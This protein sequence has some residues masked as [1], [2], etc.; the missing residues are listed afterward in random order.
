MSELPCDIFV[1]QAPYRWRSG[2]PGFF[3][4]RLEHERKSLARLI[5]QC[6]AGH[7]IQHVDNFPSYE[8]IVF[9]GPGHF[10]INQLVMRFPLPGDFVEY[11]MTNIP[12]DER[13]YGK[14]LE[15]LRRVNRWYMRDVEE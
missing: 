4:L 6:E 2:H 10:Y 11:I 15:F 7:G 9:H 13:S 5:R 12:D 1:Y 3:G 8:E 14:D